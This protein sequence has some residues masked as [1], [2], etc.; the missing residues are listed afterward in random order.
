MFISA[1]TRIPNNV[2]LQVHS[3]LPGDSH[4]PPDLRTT[5]LSQPRGP[6]PRTAKSC[7][8]I[9]AGT[10]RRTNNEGKR[11]QKGEEQR[12]ESW[13]GSSTCPTKTSSPVSQR[14]DGQI[15]L[16][17]PEAPPRVGTW[18]RFGLYGVIKSDWS[19]FRAWALYHHRNNVS[20]SCSL[21]INNQTVNCSK[22]FF[23]WATFK[24]W[25]SFSNTCTF[26]FSRS[27][28]SHELSSCASLGGAPT[29]VCLSTPFLFFFLTFDNV[30]VDSHS[31]AGTFS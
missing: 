28:F 10:R 6:N 2:L 3:R 8:P 13:T 15:H 19:I 30:K 16:L 25:T 11:A 4:H 26:F 23:Y 18:Q 5:A 24:I 20:T 21:Q 14:T 27:V 1:T 7:S 12:A 22:V 29:N 9:T 17:E 31:P